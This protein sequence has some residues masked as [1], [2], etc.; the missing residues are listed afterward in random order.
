[1]IEKGIRPGA[2]S[3]NLAF[4]EDSTIY[5]ASISEIDKAVMADPQTSGGLLFA[6]PSDK[7][8]EFYNQLQEANVLESSIIGQFKT[9]R[10]IVVL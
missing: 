6:V 5:S 3:R 2:T 4:V 10:G 9:G 1:M 8:K 7:V